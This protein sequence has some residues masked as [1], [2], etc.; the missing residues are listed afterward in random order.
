MQECRS[1]K[2]DLNKFEADLRYL[3]GPEESHTYTLAAVSFFP[4][5]NFLASSLMSHPKAKGERY[6]RTQTNER[7]LLDKAT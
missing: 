3:L 6:L 2:G 1:A 5:T 4:S 7:I